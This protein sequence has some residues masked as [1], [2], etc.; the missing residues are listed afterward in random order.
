MIDTSVMK[1]LI[2]YNTSILYSDRQ[3]K[4]KHTQVVKNNLNKTK[5]E[6][7][8]V[9]L[10]SVNLRIQSDYRKIRTRKNS[11]IEHFS[12]SVYDTSEINNIIIHYLDY[13]LGTVYSTTGIMD[14]ENVYQKPPSITVHAK[15]K[16]RKYQQIV[17]SRP[18]Q[19]FQNM[20]KKMQ[21]GKN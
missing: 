7:V 16:A 21:D 10:Y 13:R 17:L 18:I 1:E 9:E 11:V 5:T 15:K 19:N 4:L 14:H 12:R 2:D 20:L 8:Q 3:M 6:L